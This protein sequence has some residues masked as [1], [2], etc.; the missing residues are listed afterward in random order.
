[1]A[2]ATSANFTGAP[3][4]GYAGT[5]AWLHESCLPSLREIVLALAEKGYGLRL[6]DAYRPDR[7]VKAMLR[8][9]R[10]QGHSDWVE[11]GYLSTESRHSKGCAVDVTLVDLKTGLALDMGTEW[12]AFSDK[13]HSAWGQGIVRQNRDLLRDP[14]VS[15]GWRAARTEWWHFDLDVL[16]LPRLDVSYRKPGP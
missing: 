5:R 2:Y 3:L 7:S 6:F 14:F 1:M 12:D 13:S 10:D 11:Q 16:D 4:P 15:R 9:A 8:W